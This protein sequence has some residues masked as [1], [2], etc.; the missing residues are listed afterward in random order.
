MTKE[1]V[2]ELRAILER[3]QATHRET[4]ALLLEAMAEIDSELS[5][6]DDF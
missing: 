4:G 3:I 1:K 2:E 6:P 5:P